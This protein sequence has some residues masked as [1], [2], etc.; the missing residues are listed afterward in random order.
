MDVTFRPLAQPSAMSL[1]GARPEPGGSQD[2]RKAAEGFES[3]FVSELLKGGRA[4]L[5]G[6]DLLGNAGVD[7]ARDLLDMELARA[8][9]GRAGLGIADAIE[10][11]FAPL[12]KG[13]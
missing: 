7:A 2:L 3:L 13:R 5:P 9:A 12:V 4:G 8:A 6:G 10:R 11:Q 1:S